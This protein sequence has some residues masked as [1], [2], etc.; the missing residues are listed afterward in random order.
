M[1]NGVADKYDVC[2]AVNNSK[3]CCQSFYNHPVSNVHLPVEFSTSVVTGCTYIWIVSVVE[4]R[5]RHVSHNFTRVS[6]KSHEQKVINLMCSKA[7][8]VEV[9]RHV[10][11]RFVCHNKYNIAI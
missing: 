7:D 10:S 11:E 2:I 9:D 6:T 8:L 1:L 3:I 4:T 5:Y